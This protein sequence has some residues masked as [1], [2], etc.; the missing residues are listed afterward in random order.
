MN[1]LSE[2]YSSKGESLPSLAARA[3]VYAALHL[4]S[5]D[6]YRGTPDQNNAL[7]K[8]L[9]EEEIKNEVKPSQENS[10][11]KSAWNILWDALSQMLTT[12]FSA[13]TI[14]S[15]TQPCPELKE[16]PVVSTP[17]EKQIPISD[18]DDLIR[19]IGDIIA[20]GEGNYE[21]Y[22]SGTKGVEGGRVGHSFVNPSTGTVTSRTI[23]QILNTGSLSGMDSNRMFATG[24]YQ[25]I[26]ETL[27]GAKQAMGLTG[28]ELYDANLQERVFAE[29]LLEKAG[30][31]ALAR[32]VKDGIG[33]IEDAQYAAAKEWASIAAPVGKTIQDGRTSNGN[34]SYYDSPAN[35]ANSDS[36]SA[37]RAILQ[38]IQQSR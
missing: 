12:F 31:G 29:Y 1:T 5:A 25:T 6:S 26:I 9:K 34:M 23:N 35:R 24:K 30:G 14:G 13:N 20:H 33:T 28:D 22:N 21:S 17:F 38:E 36:T 4:G 32:F 2:Y 27:T 10:N 11:Q 3:K 19:R 16:S 37:L 8:A 18:L 15:P 7:L